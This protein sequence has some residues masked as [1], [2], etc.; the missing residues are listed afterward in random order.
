M[1][2]TYGI[3]GYPLS[4]SF[5]PAYFKKKFAKLSIDAVYEAYPLS[6]ITAFPDLLKTHTTLAGLNV[7]TPYKESV[8]PFLDETDP[9]AAAIG[10][11]NCIVLKDGR[12]KGYNTDALGF[13]HSLNPLLNHHHTQALVLGTGGSSKAVAYA[14]EQ[15]GIPFQ[16]VSRYSRPGG[17]CYVDLTTEIINNHKLI[18]NTTPLGMYPNVDAAPDIPYEGV[19]NTH[20]LYDLIYNPEETRFLAQG[21]AHGATTKNG[22][23]MLQLQAEASWDIWRRAAGFE[24]AE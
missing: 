21:R 3:I 5:S 22:F 4:H 18:I 7:T 10:A 9:M 15:L 2:T 1:P 17:L 13:E 24:S 16:K 12:K 11:V 20:L 6:S 19:G 23:E 8:Q 14:L